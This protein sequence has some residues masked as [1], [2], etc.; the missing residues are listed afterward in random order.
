MAEGAR[1]GFDT[2]VAGMRPEM[3]GL[4][5]RIEALGMLKHYKLGRTY[6]LHRA[7]FAKA[8]EIGGITVPDVVALPYGT[9]KKSH[10][11]L[12]VDGLILALQSPRNPPEARSQYDMMLN[13]IPDLSVVGSTTNTTG[14]SFLQTKGLSDFYQ[15]LGRGEAPSHNWVMRSSDEDQTDWL[16]WESDVTR[17][18][19]T[20]F[21]LSEIPQ[22]GPTRGIITHTVLDAYLPQK[23]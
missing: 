13:P 4:N 18:L 10:I 12:G 1:P 6:I 2:V 16:Q 15:Y 14:L 5:A 20:S 21:D 7:P 23:R 9:D 11:L 8:P 17:S 3:E 22:K 19:N